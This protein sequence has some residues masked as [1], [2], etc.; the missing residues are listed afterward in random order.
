MCDGKN[1]TSAQI[2]DIIFADQTTTQR[3]AGGKKMHNIAD[4]KLL[5]LRP[6]DIISTIRTPRQFF[7]LDELKL[8]ADSISANGIIH[9]LAVRKGI[10]GKYSLITGERRLRAAKM[11][12]IRRIPC[13]LYKADDKTAK[14]YSLVENLHQSRLNIFE[15]AEFINSLILECGLTQSQAATSL[16]LTQSSIALKLKLLHLDKLTRQKSI[17]YNLTEA[18][19]RTLLKLPESLR[20]DFAD[21]IHLN[22]LTVTDT[23]R[24]VYETLNPPKK[25]IEKPPE[26]KKE[27]PPPFSTKAAI[28]DI[29]LFENSLYKLS[30]TLSSA[31]IESNLKTTETTKYIEYRI[32]VEKRSLETVKYKQL[33]IC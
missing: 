8:L 27:E 33:K 11:A 2:C 16:G 9:P 20:P 14:I 1:F 18:H 5:M 19:A 25:I 29:R 23:E 30:E 7:D 10:K 3:S 17:D 22:S 32:R 24:L 21:K 12:G 26:Q 13:I 4:K 15:Q 28:G 31:G 6:C